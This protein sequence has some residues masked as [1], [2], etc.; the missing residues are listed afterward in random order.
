MKKTKIIYVTID[1]APSSRMRKRVDYLFEKG[2]PALWFCRGDYIKQRFDDVVYAL[3]KGYIIGNHSYSHPHFSSLS[4]RQIYQEIRK[5]DRI[6]QFAYEKAN[7][8]QYKKYFRFPYG[9]KGGLFFN[10]HY[11]RYEGEGLRR[12]M[13]IQKFLKTNGYS[14][15]VIPEVTYPFYHKL[16]FSSD[17]DMFWTYDTMDW[18]IEKKQHP[19]GID[20]IEKILERM[21]KKSLR[22]RL[23]LTYRR[24]AD[25][26]L[27]HD[28]AKTT[29]VFPAIIKKLIAQNV[30]FKSVKR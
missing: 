4:L 22:Q 12:K 19:S 7:I 5:T 30:E 28:H 25:I 6:I 11:G 18:V 13:L 23:G 2:I 29:D 16:G 17:Y 9:D 10:E 14:N 3:K 15:P 21:D 20:S 1:D 26:V 24:S 8:I 27:M